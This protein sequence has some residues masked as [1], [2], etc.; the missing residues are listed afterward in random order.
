[1]NYCKRCILPNTRPGISINDDGICSGCVGHDYK[2]QRID[3]AARGQALERIVA[4]AKD[5][6]IGYDCIVPVSGGKDSWYQVIKCQELGLNPLAVTW[7]SPARTAL[8]QQ[9]LS[10]LITKLGVDHI[11]YTIDPDVE[12]RFMKVAFEQRGDPGL[13]MHMAIFVIPTRL[14]AQ[15]RIPLVVWGENP[16]LEFG[17]TDDERLATDLDHAWLSKHGCMQ[18]TTAADWIGDNLTAHDLAAYMLPGESGFVPKMIFLGAFL[19]WDSFENAGTARD[20]GFTFR[21]DGALTGVWEFADIDCAFISLHHLPKWHKFGISRAF[22]NLSVEIR[23]GRITRD[24]AVNTL[25]KVGMQ[26]PRD[27]IRAFCEFEREPESWFWETC[28][29]FRNHDIWE[30]VGTV[31]RVRDFLIEDFPWECA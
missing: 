25:R 27:D 23:H 4:A 5:R 29:T 14:A 20:H 17:G 12:R 11:D 7:R 13:P 30:R 15:M 2:E 26:V 9:N 19:K 16:Q 28:E 24:E 1:M 8:G 22:D 6:A 21:D 10:G 18:G 31:W 3:W